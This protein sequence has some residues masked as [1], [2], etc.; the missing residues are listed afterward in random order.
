MGVYKSE[1][2]IY[3]THLQSVLQCFKTSHS[4]IMTYDIIPVLEL[5]WSQRVEHIVTDE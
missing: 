2:G 1:P 4:Q 5:E 3:L